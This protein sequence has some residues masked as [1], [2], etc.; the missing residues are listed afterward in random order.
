MGRFDV[1]ATWTGLCGILRAELGD[2]TY[3]SW[4]AQ[5]Q[6]RVLGEG[7][8]R[9]GV[10]RHLGMG[11]LEAVV[12]EDLLVVDDDAV[13]DPDHGAVPDLVVVRLDRGMAL[14]VVTYVHE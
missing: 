6:L 3:G 1:A 5:A 4:L 12:G 13:V 14:G 2:N 10:D 8:D 11:A 9:L 7:E